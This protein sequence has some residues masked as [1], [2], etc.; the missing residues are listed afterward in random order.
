M[1]AGV[2]VGLEKK[3][4]GIY[5]YLDHFFDNLNFEVKNY[6]YANVTQSHKDPF[7]RIGRIQKPLLFP[8]EFIDK[9]RTFWKEERSG[10]SF[11]GLVTKYRYPDL[12]IWKNRARIRHTG[13]GRK[14]LRRFWDETYF[15]EMGRS[16]FILCP[17]GE[18]PWTYRVIEAVLS[19]AT[20]II[21]TDCSWYQGLYYHKWNDTKLE[22]KYVEENFEWV[23]SHLTLPREIIREE[24]WN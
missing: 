10:I 9:V 2:K 14:T 12:K 18:M 21:Q 19:G 5:K 15:Q 7:V 13:R 22:R 8:H 24:L 23:K 1:E 16:E 11:S 6:P 20:P 3:D 4:L 17:N